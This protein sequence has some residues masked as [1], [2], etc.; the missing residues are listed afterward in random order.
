[1]TRLTDN[2]FYTYTAIALD[3]ME[4]LF[5]ELGANDPEFNLRREQA[6]IFCAGEPST[7]SSTTATGRPMY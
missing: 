3:D 6:L 1:M 5:T 7:K 4:V 2:R